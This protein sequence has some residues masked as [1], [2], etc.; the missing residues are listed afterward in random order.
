MDNIDEKGSLT[1]DQTEKLTYLFDSLYAVNNIC[2]W[3]YS[4][5]WEL[6]DTNCPWINEVRNFF[7][8]SKDDALRTYESG[9]TM[10]ILYP[11]RL[12]LT[13]AIQPYIANKQPDSFYVLGPFLTS[14]ISEINFKR[15]LDDWHM[16]IASQHRMME[17][18]KEIPVI[19][20]ALFLQSV[21]M[22]YYT[23]YD[24]TLGNLTTVS[25]PTLSTNNSFA[26]TKKNSSIAHDIAITEHSSYAMECAMLRHVETGNIH[27][28]E[29]LGNIELSADNYLVG[30][31]SPND[32]V[33]QEKDEIIVFVALITRAAIRGGMDPDEAYSLSDYYI[34]Q[35]ESPDCTDANSIM[36]IHF[37]AYDTF[38]RR[39]HEIQAKEVTYAPFIHDCIA[40]IHRNIYEKISLED[41][42][43]AL[44]YSTYYLSSQFKKQTGQSIG[45]YMTNLRIEKAKEMLAYSNISLTDLSAKL[46]FSTPSYFSSVFKKHTGLTPTEYVHSL[47]KPASSSQL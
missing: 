11:D 14:S 24:K 9:N 8:D 28:Q 33:R 39:V 16:S 41:L 38:I 12:C 25:F 22:L 46:H 3:H 42:A 1:M 13:W 32:I 37:L 4:K 2:F 43:G 18:Q 21:R 34:Q 45:D 35:I 10:P 19:P 17:V 6:L 44:G 36:D 15:L 30:L 20:Y 26:P 23:L 47:S 31:M 7:F 27:Y 5:N 40:L 29:E